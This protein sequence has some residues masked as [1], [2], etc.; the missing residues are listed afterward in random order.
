MHL[1]FVPK[2]NKQMGRYLDPG[3]AARKSWLNPGPRKRRK[4]LAPM[5]QR[6]IKGYGVDSAIVDKYV[7]QSTRPDKLRHGKSI[8]LNLVSQLHIF[9]FHISNTT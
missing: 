4:P 2:E 6:L 3:A 1:F 5:Y 7:K 8:N 9:I